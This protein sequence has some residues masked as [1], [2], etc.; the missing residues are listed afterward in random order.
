MTL[1]IPLAAVGAPNN[2]PGPVYLKGLGVSSLSK[3]SVTAFSTDAAHAVTLPSSPVHENLAVPGEWDL[4]RLPL[5]VG[6]RLELSVTGP[7]GSVFDLYLYSPALVNFADAV[8]VA[9]ASEGGY[10]RTITYDVPVSGTYF[11]EVNAFSGSGA[12]ELTW[13]VREPTENMRVDVAAAVTVTVPTVQ[14]ITLEDRW[15]ANRLF[16]ISLP[17]GRRVQVALSGPAD[18][19]FDIYLYAPGTPSILPRNVQ[20]LTWSNSP[21]S[22]ERF[23]FDVPDGVSRTYFLE[24]LRFRGGGPARLSVIS[25]PI[26]AAPSAT[27]VWGADRFATAAAISRRAYPAGSATA[28]LASGRAFS[29]GLAASSLAGVLNAPILLTELHSLPALTLAELRRLRVSKVFIAGGSGAI[30]P[31]VEGA[32]RAGI[33]GIEIERIAGDDRYGTAAKIAE[34]VREITGQRP[35]RVFLASGENFPDAL[36]LSPIAFATREP[37]ILT[38]RSVLPTVSQAAI[39]N[40]RRPG[41]TVDLLIA[42]GTGAVAEPAATAASAAAGGEVLRKYGADR[43]GTSLAIAEFAVTQR[44][45]PPSTLTLA[46]GVTFPDALA[47]APLAGGEHGSLLLTLPTA[48]SSQARNYLRSF[49]FAVNE[50]WILGGSGAVSGPVLDSVVNL[51]PKTPLP[52]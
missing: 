38:R 34:R 36:S 25:Y 35:G 42:G 5:S 43:Y 26:P 17:A 52:R 44:P 13:R 8:A 9:H 37:I 27:R 1:V 29:D 23:I 15:G 4:Y 31:A 32:L 11:I 46:S 30:A 48:L 47:G 45:D 7:P 3:S 22:N 33:P 40:L 6:Q 16:A 39:T 18:A 19:D 10:P 41:D 21:V 24:V 12:Y 51:L 14:D 49:D 50:C 20:P 28:V 2:S